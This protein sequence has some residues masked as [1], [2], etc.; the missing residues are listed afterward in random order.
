VGWRE[1]RVGENESRFRLVNERIRDHTIEEADR[2][3]EHADRLT[4]VC[5]CADID[6]VEKIELPLSLYEWVRSAAARFVVFPGHVVT[7][8]ERV[9][10][11]MQAF[12][13]VEKF[14]D[15][16]AAASELDPRNN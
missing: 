14:G 10:R 5:E 6:C 15:A 9:V 4:V 2:H 3:A 13:V 1:Q 11:D 16:R 8:S 12:V 7:D